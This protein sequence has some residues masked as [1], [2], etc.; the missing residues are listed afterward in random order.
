[1]GGRCGYLGVLVELMIGALSLV[2]Y[3]QETNVRERG[4]DELSGAVVRSS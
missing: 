3:L 1:M 2:D 4:C